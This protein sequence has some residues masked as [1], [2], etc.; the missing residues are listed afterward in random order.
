MHYMS[1][2]GLHKHKGNEPRTT[3]ETTVMPWKDMFRGRSGTYPGWSLPHPDVPMPKYGEGGPRIG[4]ASLGSKKHG[5]ETHYGESH[6]SSR[7]RDDEGDEPETRK[8]RRA[9]EKEERELERLRREQGMPGTDQWKRYH[10]GKAPGRTYANDEMTNGESCFHMVWLYW[11]RGIRE[12]STHDQKMYHT[13]TG[14][15]RFLTSTHD[16]PLRQRVPRA[17][18]RRLSFRIRM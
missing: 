5:S 13:T 14:R 6:G 11:I 18:L 2:E 9:R 3:A 1:E 17:R 8:E 15:F 12:W 4:V 7:S 10:A 16:G